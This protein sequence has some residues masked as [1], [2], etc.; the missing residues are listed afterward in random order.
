MSRGV[1]L[2]ASL[3]ILLTLVFAGCDG[4][5]PASESAGIGSRSPG[6]ET[7]PKPADISEL[8]RCTTNASAKAVH[9]PLQGPWRWTESEFVC[10]WFQDDTM[11]KLQILAWQTP[12][13]PRGP[14]ATDIQTVQIKGDHVDY[15][16]LVF[17]ESRNQ[18]GGGEFGAVPWVLEAYG[19]RT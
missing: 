14:W 7:T 1:R 6:G 19:D 5:E 4:R 11:Q 8:G 15:E 18:T 13:L 12:P 2:A 10:T 9:I 16:G 3:L 17:H